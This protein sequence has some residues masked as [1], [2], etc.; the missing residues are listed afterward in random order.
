MSEKKE[1]KDAS[2]KKT[3][4]FLVSVGLSVFLDYEASWRIVKLMKWSMGCQTVS[5]ALFMLLINISF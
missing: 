3:R 2:K 1:R 4:G 5:T